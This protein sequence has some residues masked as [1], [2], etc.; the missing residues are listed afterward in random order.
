MMKTA[1]RA[2]GKW[3][4]ILLTLGI[5]AKFLSKKHGPCPF[6]GGRDRFRW[7]DKDG[8]GTFFCSQCGSGDGIE[9]LKRAKGWDFRTAASEIDGVVGGVSAEPA[10]P[11]PDDRQRLDM[12]KRLWETARPLVPGDPVCTYL[13]ERDVLPANNPSCLRFAARCPV[14]DGGGFAPAMIALVRAPDGAS[15]TIHRTFLAD[16]APGEKRHRA[17]MPG[18]I[19]D[20]SAVRLCAVD[21]DTLGIG[22]GIETTFAAARRFNVP[23][24]AALNAALMAKWIPPETVKRVLIFGDHDPAFGG[25]AATYA[26]AHRLVTRRRLQVEV[27]IPPVVGTDWADAA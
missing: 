22:E 3:R 9:F 6:C 10:R 12:L 16:P 8:K 4:G 25:Q 2:R 24:W 14:P 20:G 7:D 13:A 11:K 27:H 19:P 18:T 26:L 23:A 1:E 15:A 21:G 17:M 5:E